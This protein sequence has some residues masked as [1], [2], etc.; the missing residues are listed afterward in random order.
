MVLELLPKEEVAVDADKNKPAEGPVYKGP[1]R[2]KG[3][4]RTQAD[5]RD[6]VRFETKTDRR[7][8]KERRKT[9]GLWKD[10]D[11]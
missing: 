4:R 2:R 6:M 9:E 10:R 11:F 5:R 7:G 1:E 3:P 8:G